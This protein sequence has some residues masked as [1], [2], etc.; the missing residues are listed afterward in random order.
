MHLES[1]LL[2]ETT[3]RHFQLKQ[4]Q[5]HTFG[6]LKRARVPQKV[7]FFGHRPVGGHNPIGSI[8]GFAS[9][10]GSR[11]TEGFALLPFATRQINIEPKELTQRIPLLFCGY[12]N[13]GISNSNQHISIYA[14]MLCF[15]LCRGC[16][17][18]E[19]AFQKGPGSQA[20]GI[21]GRGVNL[22]SEWELFSGS[23]LSGSMLIGGRVTPNR[24][25]C[26]CHQALG[27]H[28]STNEAANK[29][30]RGW[31]EPKANR[32]GLL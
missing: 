2:S 18:Q 31:S 22:R 1:G 25:P 20:P 27:C 28:A 14:G 32:G 21:S 24:V 17:S 4:Y 12:A 11:K 5:W 26:F 23:H 3:H 15:W 8:F 16:D 6:P 7:S 13:L 30:I 19:P 9:T 29:S 10:R